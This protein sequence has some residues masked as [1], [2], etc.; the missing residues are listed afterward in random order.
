MTGSQ[1]NML[2]GGCRLSWLDEGW[3]GVV[4][5]QGGLAMISLW[6]CPGDLEN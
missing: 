3:G 6:S 1:D 4:G 5:S 2:V